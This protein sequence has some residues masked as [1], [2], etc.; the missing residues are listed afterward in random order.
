MHILLMLA[1]GLGLLAAVHAGARALGRDGSSRT[2]ARGAGLFVCLWLVACI[3]DV[4]LGVGSA[5]SMGASQI[6]AHAVIFA[7]P[8]ALAL[9]LAIRASKRD[10]ARPV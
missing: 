4:T 10:P 9:A 6:A 8:V 2:V 5:G 3:A 1:V 7:V